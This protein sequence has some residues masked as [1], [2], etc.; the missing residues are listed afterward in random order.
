MPV[1]EKAKQYNHNIFA[2]GTDLS[3]AKRSS[4]VMKP[5][6]NNEGF[7]DRHNNLPFYSQEDRGQHSKQ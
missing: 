7:K 1:M 3:K 5:I 6:G 2:N 4:E